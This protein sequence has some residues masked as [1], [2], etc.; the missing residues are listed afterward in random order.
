M[1][2]K[3]DEESIT[4]FLIELSPPLFAIVLYFI[5]VDVSPDTF[6]RERPAE[7]YQKLRRPV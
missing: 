6:S 7:K 3:F 5:P 2:I 4:E 1:G